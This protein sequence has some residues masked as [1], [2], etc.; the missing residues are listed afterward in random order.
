MK[1]KMEEEELEKE[2]QSLK[3]EMKEFREEMQKL[4]ESLKE[5]KMKRK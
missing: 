2:M 5:E 1:D 4:S 3:L